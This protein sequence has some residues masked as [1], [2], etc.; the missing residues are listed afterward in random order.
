MSKLYLNW[1]ET[2]EEHILYG[3][4]TSA[5]Q[6]KQMQIGAKGPFLLRTGIDRKGVDSFESIRRHLWCHLFCL[7]FVLVSGKIHQGYC[8]FA[9]S[10]IQPKKSATTHPIL[11]FVHALSQ[12]FDQN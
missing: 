5:V 12:W 6:P 10:L 2:S 9:Q 7:E 3:S 1:P 8:R 11:L 4:V